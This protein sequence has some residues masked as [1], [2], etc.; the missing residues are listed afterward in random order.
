VFALDA[1]LNN[2]AINDCDSLSLKLFH[3]AF[4]V[5]QIHNK[6]NELRLGISKLSYKGSKAHLNAQPL[7]GNIKAFL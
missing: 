6:N 7:S 2:L 1:D 3:M 4:A 5:Q